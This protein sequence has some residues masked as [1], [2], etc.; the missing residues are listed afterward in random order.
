[1]AKKERPDSATLSKGLV[2]MLVP[3]YILR[4]FEI[5]NIKEQKDCWILELREQ[6]DRIPDFLASYSDVVLDGFCNP[7]ELQSHTFAALKPVYLR[8]Y[9]RR[10]KRS[11]T[12]RHYSNEYILNTPGIKMVK[13]L[14][15][16]LK[17]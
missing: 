2:R 1:M 4:D 7:I 12:D 3:D 8:C 5:H 16:F 17:G 13:E 14:G 10:W 15:D 6:Q 11:N 9:R